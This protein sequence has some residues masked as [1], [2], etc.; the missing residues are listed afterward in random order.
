ML[1]DMGKILED[2]IPGIITRIQ[3]I[4][5][6]AQ[7]PHVSP[8]QQCHNLCDINMLWPLGINATQTG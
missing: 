3:Q 1:N 2:L 5:G 8:E 7:T 4:P 6:V